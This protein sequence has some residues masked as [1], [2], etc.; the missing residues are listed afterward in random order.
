MVL[1]GTPTVS[2]F[3]YLGTIGTFGFMVSYALVSVAAPLWLSKVGAAGWTVV[4]GPVAAVAMGYVF[5]KNVYPAPP[6]PFNRL[7]WIFVAL[8]AAGGAYYTLVRLRRPETAASMGTF[9]ERDALAVD[10][11]SAAEATP[12]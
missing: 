1:N 4:A 11:P 10:T 2:A 7:P 9:G 3:A 5:Y 6:E 12:A 8:M